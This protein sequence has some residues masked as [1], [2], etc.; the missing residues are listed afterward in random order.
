LF[1]DLLDTLTPLRVAILGFGREGRSTYAFLRKHFPQKPLLIADKAQLSLEDENVTLLCG[2][3]YLDVL[4]RCDLCVKTPGISLR[5]VEIP[6]SVRVSC[7]T[8]LFLRYAPCVSIGVTGSKGKTT[9]ATLIFEMLRAAQIPALL[10][11]NMGVPTLDYLEN[12][13]NSIAVIEMSSHQL[14][15]TT[16]SP[17]IA[18]WTNLYEEHLDHYNN[19][20]AGYAAAKAHICGAQTAEDY[21]IYCPNQSPLV[22]EIVAAT[23]SNAIPVRLNDQAENPFLQRL[24][25]V[26]SD[27]LRGNHNLQ[28]IFFAERAAR[29]CGADDE[30]IARTAAWYAGTPHRLESLGTFDGIEWVDDCIATIPEAVLRGIEALETVDTLIFGGLD[31]GIDY[32]SF[33]EQLAKTSVRH[34]ICM[35]ETGHVIAKRLADYCDGQSIVSVQSLEE[36]VSAAR[37]LTQRGSICLLSPAAASYNRYKNF[38]EKGA[39]FISLV[40]AI[41]N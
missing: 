13:E 12:V 37:A 40:T 35:P 2:D 4:R 33:A 26:R 16:V 41:G 17:H 11:G 27:R 23:Q 1:A 29:L 9:T 6:A 22:D 38:E 36:A 8:D 14:E 34:F 39:H 10:L 5:G 28:N 15:F 24:A 19:G 31:R 25:M 21:V 32:G 20:F 7:Q 30:S 3:N 18:V